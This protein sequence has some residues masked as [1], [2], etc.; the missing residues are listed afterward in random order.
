MG[1]TTKISSVLVLEMQIFTPAYIN[2]KAYIQ[3][4][5]SEPKLLD[6]YIDN[7]DFFTRLSALITFL[8]N[9]SK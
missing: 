9:A 3:K 7:K 2:M 5:L 8:L 6:V 4:I 1:F